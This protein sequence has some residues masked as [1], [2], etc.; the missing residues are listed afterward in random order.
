M[1]KQFMLKKAA[2]QAGIR[3][4]P[5]EEGVFTYSRAGRQNPR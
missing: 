4:I 3:L 5:F 2:E 1:S